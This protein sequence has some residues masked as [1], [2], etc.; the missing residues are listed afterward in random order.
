MS[1]ELALNLHFDPHNPQKG[2]DKGRNISKENIYPQ[3][4]T[5]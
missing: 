3:I 5:A 2:G 1:T 4:I